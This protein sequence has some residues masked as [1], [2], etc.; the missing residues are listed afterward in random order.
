MNGKHEEGALKGLREDCTCP[1][2]K[3]IICNYRLIATSIAALTQDEG[4]KKKRRKSKTKKGFEFP[5]LRHLRSFCV[6]KKTHRNKID[7]YLGCAALSELSLCVQVQTS[8]YG[9]LVM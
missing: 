2:T 6:M 7:V 4:E 3:I 1:I 8:I 5:P 9:N